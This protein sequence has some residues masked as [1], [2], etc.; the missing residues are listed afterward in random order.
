MRPRE[1]EATRGIDR[2]HESW[3]IRASSRGELYRSCAH[4]QCL[5]QVEVAVVVCGR[6]IDMQR[7]ESDDDGAVLEYCDVSGTA[8]E[9]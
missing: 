9:F 3:K 7:G 2:V 8:L 1:Y 4:L 6:L 5:D